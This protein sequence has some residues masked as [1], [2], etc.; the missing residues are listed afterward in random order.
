M[1]TVYFY[2]IVRTQVMV[3]ITFHTKIELKVSLVH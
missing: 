2:I 1:I 3:A